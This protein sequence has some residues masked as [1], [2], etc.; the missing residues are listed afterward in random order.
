M[1]IFKTIIVMIVM[2]VPALISG[3]S[4]NVVD[5]S[6]LD[7]ESWCG[8]HLGDG[9]ADVFYDTVEN[10]SP[11]SFATF[12]KELDNACVAFITDEWVI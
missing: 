8:L 6:N 2:L 5:T 12:E 7:T 9:A 11:R 1:N 4:A 10:A 3:V